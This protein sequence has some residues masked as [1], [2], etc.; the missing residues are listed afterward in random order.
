MKAVKILLLAVA[1]LLVADFAFGQTWTQTSAPAHEWTSIASSA[2]GTKLVAT[3][4]AGGAFTGSIYTSTNS[5]GTWTSNNVPGLQQWRSVASSADGVNLAAAV[6]YG[7]IYISTNSGMAWT[8]CTNAPNE[9]W[10]SIASSADGTKLVVAPEGDVSGNALPIYISADSGIT[11]TATTAPSNNWTAV[12]SSADGTKLAASVF[13]GPIYTSTNSGVTWMSNSVPINYWRSV[14]SSAD[15]TKLVAATD[16]G[17]FI[18]TST[19][20]G[21]TWQPHFINGNFGSAASSADGVRLAVVAYGISG[22]VTHI[23]VSTNSGSTWIAQ[24]SA[25][26]TDWQGI[27]SSADGQKLAAG[28]YGGGIYTSY[29]TPAPQMNITPSSGNLALSWTIP[30]TNFV[31]QQSSDLT[32]WADVTNAPALNLT[33]LQNQVMLSPSNNSSF[34]RL[35]TP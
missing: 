14:A 15:G 16:P 3:A 10:Y 21:A 8:L 4:P 17:T 24:N 7:G 22:G 18:Y 23:Y 20:S 13:N 29:S 12:C 9:Y 35:K 6:A 34:Y 32:S 19:N 27:V 2:D 5:G 28:I 25:P 1:T 30:S 11:W 26:N 31:L 33:N